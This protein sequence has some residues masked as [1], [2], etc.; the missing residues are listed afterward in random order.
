MGGVAPKVSVVL[1]VN[2]DDGYLCEAIASI[3]SQ[4]LADFEL[5]IIANCCN[6]LLWSTLQEFEDSRIIL[7]RTSIGQLPFNLNVAVELAK[8]RY[9]ARMDADDVCEPNRLEKQFLY[10]E[11]HRDID[12]VGSEYTHIDGAGRFIGRPRPLKLTNTAIIRQ[13][14]F[15]SCMPH[16]TVMFRRDAVLAVGGYAY[17]LYAEDWDLWLRMARSGK[18]FANIDEPLLRYRI[19]PAQSTS[20]SAARRNTANV[21]G[22]LVRELIITGRIVFVFGIVKFLISTIFR[23]AVARVRARNA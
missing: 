9:I 22:L 18:R 15:E 4:S 11:K 17:G 20:S 5:I 1:A 7:R 14:P 19:H 12:V 10:L 2:R 13:L 8:A 3:L 21:V 6:E 23:H 16:P